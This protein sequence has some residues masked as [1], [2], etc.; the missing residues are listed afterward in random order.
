M[1]EAPSLTLLP[2]LMEIEQLI[3]YLVGNLSNKNNMKIIIFLYAFSG[4]TIDGSIIYE[5]T[6]KPMVRPGKTCFVQIDI[7][8]T[9]RNGIIETQT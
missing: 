7:G 9:R 1:Q 5:A 2:R 8:I 4:L 6:I 3:T